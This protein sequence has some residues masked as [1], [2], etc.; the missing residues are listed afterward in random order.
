M[1]D[2]KHH[3]LVTGELV[4]T[5]KDADNIHAL[6]LNAVVL[7]DTADTI[8]AR[9]IGAAQQALQMQFHQRMDN[10]EVTVRDVVI[11]NMLYLGNMT[12][13]EFQRPP[14][15]MRKQEVEDQVAKAVFG[16]AL[17]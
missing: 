11:M 1:S 16:D 15:N 14:E 2:K 7:G 12:A 6:R 3:Y 8:P 17:H 5:V 4:Y 13:E 10:P 9:A